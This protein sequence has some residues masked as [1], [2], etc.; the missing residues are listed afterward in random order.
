MDFNVRWKKKFID[1]FSDSL[2]QLN[3]KTLPLTMVELWVNIKEEYS[4]LSEKAVKKL[5]P[6]L[7]YIS[8]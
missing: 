3:V 2:L 5:L 6:L 1:V 4:Q 8:I 7:N